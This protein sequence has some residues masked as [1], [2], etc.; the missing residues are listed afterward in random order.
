MK[1]RT[2]YIQTG[3]KGILAH[4]PHPEKVKDLKK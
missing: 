1:L 4:D 2:G 3:S